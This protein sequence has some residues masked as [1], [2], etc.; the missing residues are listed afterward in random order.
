MCHWMPDIF[1]LCLVA[2]LSVAT[3]SSNLLFPTY[4]QQSSAPHQTRQHSA[5]NISW[6]VVCRTVRSCVRNGRCPGK[7]APRS[8]IATNHWLLWYLKRDVFS[9]TKIFPCTV[10][11]TTLMMETSIS[12]ETLVSKHRNRSQAFWKS[13]IAQHTLWGLWP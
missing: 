9:Y 4:I 1:R 11:F 8:R 10:Q 5:G 7:E 6:S 12:F 2:K 3:A 13:E